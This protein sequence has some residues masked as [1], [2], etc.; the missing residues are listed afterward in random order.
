MRHPKAD[1][2]AQQAFREKIEGYELDGRSIVYI[3]ESGFATDMPRTHGYAPKG[4]R[5]I[6]EHDWNAKG[7]VNVIGAL[8]AGV[9][10]SV[11]LTEA[12]VDADLFNL[13]LKGD[14]IPKL[15]PA[16]VL[17]MDRATFHRRADTKA[18]IAAAG[19]TLEYL[20]A[21]SPELNDIEHKWAEAKAYRRKSGKSVDDIFAEQ[22]WNQ[23]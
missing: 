23:N 14:L 3:D 18:V 5:C 10:L 17:V 12:N 21:Y 4:Q 20:P 7:R 6:G 16:A 22:N 8:M 11:G 13:W 2:A 19:H 9:L 15:P 1:A